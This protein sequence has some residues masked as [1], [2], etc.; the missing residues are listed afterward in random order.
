MRNFTAIKVASA[1]QKKMIKDEA[2][3]HLNKYIKKFKLP[4][5]QC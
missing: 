4:D 2:E 5:V 1:S 3:Y